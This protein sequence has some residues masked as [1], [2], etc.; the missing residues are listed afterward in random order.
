MSMTL[1]TMCRDSHTHKKQGHP[2]VDYTFERRFSLPQLSQR[3]GETTPQP[4][5]TG[6]YLASVFKE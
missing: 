5:L 6:C 2:P 4:Q 1:G 3:D